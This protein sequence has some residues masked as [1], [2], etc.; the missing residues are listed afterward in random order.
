M[1]ASVKMTSDEYERA[2]CAWFSSTLGIMCDWVD[3]NRTQHLR[4]STTWR[5]IP[6][7]ATLDPRRLSQNRL[8]ALVTIFDDLCDA[9]LLPA[10]QAYR[11]PVRQEMDRRILAEV[12]MLDDHAVESFTIL[13]N[14]WCAEPTVSAGKKT[15]IQYNM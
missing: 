10:C 8:G 11:D 1:W 15:S 3:S 14:Q 12:L 13:R 7:I 4:G 9:H 2:I 5:A 6:N